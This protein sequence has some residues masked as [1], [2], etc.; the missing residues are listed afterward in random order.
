MAQKDSSLFDESVSKL[1]LRH[2]KDVLAE[3]N[4][5]SDEEQSS[6]DEEHA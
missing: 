2:F 6:E 3:M 1:V 5:E 4:V